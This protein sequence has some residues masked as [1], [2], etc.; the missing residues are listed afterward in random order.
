MTDF[1]ID[2]FGG[3]DMLVRYWEPLGDLSHMGHYAD[4][5]LAK[6]L[7][8]AKL[9]T[10]SQ[11]KSGTVDIDVYQDEG[12]LIVKGAIPGVNPDELEVTITG[13]VL[14]IKGETSTGSD[15]QE[16]KFL[17]RERQHGPFVRSFKLPS[18]LKIDEIQCTYE[19]GVLG[20]I[21]PKEEMARPNSL[22]VKVVGH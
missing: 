15:S 5:L 12:N 8:A 14:K 9:N 19:S 16:E 4:R 22:K 21:I 6:S 13:D 10:Y 20:I 17:W 2:L 3:V 1:K 7:P 11:T 18:G